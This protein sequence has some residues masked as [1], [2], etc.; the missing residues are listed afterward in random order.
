[1]SQPS[2]D[3]VARVYRW[4]E[5]ASLGRTLEHAREFFLP[6]LLDRR[7]VLALGDGDGRFLAKLLQQNPEA[8]A[9]A[10][11]TS[12][13]MLKLLQ[14]RCGQRVRTLHCSALDV[15]ANS[16]TGLAADLIVTHFFLDCFTQAEVDLLVR[17]LAAQVAPGALWV[18]SDFGAPTA[19][20]LRPMAAAYVRSL[21]LAF[22]I[23][24]G[25]R[26]KHL[27]DPQRALHA[28][29]FIRRERKDF[30]MG[31]IYTELWVRT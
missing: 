25:L 2:F 26:V 18:V 7:S 16:H 17:S 24:T 11:D 21:Y 19:R 12:A 30:L 10:V 22:R 13:A 1:M 14:Q 9:V 31:L 23:L 5:Y 29:G 3:R 4:A 27:P 6:R 28:A 15:A 8:H 20:W